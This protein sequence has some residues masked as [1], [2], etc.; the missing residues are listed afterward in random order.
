MNGPGGKV[1]EQ[2]LVA[3][4]VSPPPPTQLQIPVNAAEVEIIKYMVVGGGEA[5][6]GS[7]CHRRKL[8][9]RNRYSQIENNSG[10]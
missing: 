4:A 8:G 3:R 2:P 9:M 10:Y 1:S 7:S 6:T 5:A